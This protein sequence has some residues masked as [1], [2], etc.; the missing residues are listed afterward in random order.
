MKDR[1]IV[2]RRYLMS[3]FINDNFVIVLVCEK[4]T[5]NLMFPLNVQK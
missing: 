1:L 3:M 2:T 5:A 4:V